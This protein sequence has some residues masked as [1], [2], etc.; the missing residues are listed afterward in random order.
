MKKQLITTINN[1]VELL[2]KCSWPDR[3]QWL[4]TRL[5]IINRHGEQSSEYIATLKEIQSIIAGMGSLSDLPMKPAK[6][7]GMSEAEA[8]KRKWE[9]VHELDKTITAILK[10]RKKR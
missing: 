2:E 9:L 8:H 6:E 3:A 10:S 4:R 7:S 5:A 1:I